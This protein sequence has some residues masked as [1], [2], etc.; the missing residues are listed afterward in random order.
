MLKRAGR[1]PRAR[2]W[3]PLFLVD[4]VAAARPQLLEIAA[5]LEQAGDPDPV[6]VKMLK[7]LLTDGCESPLYVRG[8]HPSEL[9]ATLYYTKR[10][11]A[12][13]ADHPP[14]GPAEQPPSRHRSSRRC[15]AHWGQT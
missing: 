1:P 9:S 14:A 5:L 7:R 6:A 4:R 13:A 15:Q 3:R 2:Q 10:R 12:P 8:I 11:L